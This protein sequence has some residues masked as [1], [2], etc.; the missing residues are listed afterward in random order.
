MPDF[1]AW[2]AIAAG[3]AA[4]VGHRQWARLGYDQNRR[5]GYAGSRTDFERT[6]VLAGLIMVTIGVLSLL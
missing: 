4:V 2:I 1:M 6:F 3:L 5:L